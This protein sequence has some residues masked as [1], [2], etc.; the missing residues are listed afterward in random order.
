LAI[1]FDLL[2]E[3]GCDVAPKGTFSFVVDG[4]REFTEDREES[5]ESSEGVDSKFVEET[6]GA[7][8]GKT[9]G[10]TNSELTANIPERLRVMSPLGVDG[11]RLGSSARK[12]EKY[13][14]VD[15]T[16][17]GCDF[18]GWSSLTEKEGERRLV[19]DVKK[20]V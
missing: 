13:E 2:A 10:G 14:T 9:A 20:K 12:T 19:V 15:S 6:V 4:V 5:S 1:L 17:D 18:R 3:D 8:C 11:I 16:Y 7:C